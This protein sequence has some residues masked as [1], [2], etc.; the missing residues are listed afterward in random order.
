VACKHVRLCGTNQPAAAAS[1]SL[2]HSKRIIIMLGFAP[3]AGGTSRSRV[4][5]LCPSFRPCGD[6]QRP[7]SALLCSADAA[8]VAAAGPT[9]SAT[10]HGAIFRII[11]E[12]ESP[13]DIARDVLDNPNAIYILVSG[14]PT[15]IRT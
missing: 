6:T 1:R 14:R 2:A 3:A 10:S 7:P 11:A 12:S 9:T 15:I 8:A 4:P 13:R 5:P